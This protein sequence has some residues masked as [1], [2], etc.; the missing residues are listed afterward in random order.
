MTP[1]RCLVSACK[2]N[3][4]DIIIVVLGAGTKSQRTTDSINL[5]NYI[6]KNFE[7]YDFKNLI[8]SSFENYINNYSDNIVINKSM[9]K[10]VLE[11]KKSNFLLPIKKNDIGNFKIST[12]TLNHIDSPIYKDFKFGVLQLYVNNTPILNVDITIKNNIP[13]TKTFEYFVYI[14]K[15]ITM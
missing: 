11:L 3:N 13:K 10:P 7:M 12:Y 1:G 8:N 5:I 14:L 6:Y 2:R 4:L 9:N 15:I